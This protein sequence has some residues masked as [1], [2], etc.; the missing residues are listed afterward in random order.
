VLQWRYGR[1]GLAIRLKALFDQ[2]CE[3]RARHML[4]ALNAIDGAIG[5]INEFMVSTAAAVE[6]QSIVGLGRGGRVNTS[7]PVNSRKSQA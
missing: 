2:Y 1:R 5:T 3:L 6:E 4:E 7:L